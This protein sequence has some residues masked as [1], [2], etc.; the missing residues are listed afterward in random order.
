[1]QYSNTICIEF[2]KIYNHNLSQTF[3]SDLFTRNINS[4]NLR[5]KPDFVIP[6]VRTV[7]KESRST[8]YYSPII[9]SLLPEEIRYTESLKKLKI[10][11]EDGNLIIFHIAFIKITS[12]MLDF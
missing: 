6:Q 7:S 12:P 1:M 11:L 10:R 2:C 9:W 4:Y 3:F 8:R 5:L